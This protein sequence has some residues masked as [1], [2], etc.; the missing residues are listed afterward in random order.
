MSDIGT[1]GVYFCARK[2]VKQAKHNTMGNILKFFTILL[3]I[4]VVL[5]FLIPVAW[6]VIKLFIGFFGDF[7]FMIGDILMIAFI[8]ICIVLIFKSIFS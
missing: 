4:G 5:V 1:S 6:L 8:V 7:A 2:I 3:L